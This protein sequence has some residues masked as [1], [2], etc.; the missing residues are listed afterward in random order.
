MWCILGPNKASAGKKLKTKCSET[1]GTLVEVI[2][3]RHQAR[4][5]DSKTRDGRMS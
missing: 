5:V 1:G 4:A 2:M 3:G